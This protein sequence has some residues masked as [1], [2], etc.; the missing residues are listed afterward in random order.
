MSSQEIVWMTEPAD[1]DVVGVLGGM[2]PLAS[3]G[4]IR[5][6]YGTYRGRVEQET[7]VVLLWSNPKLG[8]RTKIFLQ[9]GDEQELLDG[10]ETGLRSLVAQGANH[11]VICCVTAHYLLPRLPKDLRAKVLSLVDVIFEELESTERKCLLACTTGTRSLRLFQEHK[12]WKKV[13]HKVCLPTAK[14]Q[15]KL[16][17][18]IYSVK[19]D[20]TVDDLAEVVLSI[21]EAHSVDTVIAGCTELHL[22][23]SD[24]DC[25]T[26]L[27][28]KLR[29]IDPLATIATRYR[30]GMHA[31]AI[32]A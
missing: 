22:L 3:A 27:S 6:L 30:E 28:Q 31:A 17:E 15:E 14:E 12:G 29:I 7:P 23:S 18:A 4:F 16:H 10:L 20:H 13:A 1:R 11:L 5:T 26:A 19:R 21:C 32:R 2:G 8:D 9:N 25:R 24:C